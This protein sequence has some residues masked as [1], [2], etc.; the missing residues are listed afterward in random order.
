MQENEIVNAISRL[1][2]IYVLQIKWIG[3]CKLP[4]WS[5]AGTCG[6]VGAFM[7]FVNRL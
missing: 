4:C 1:K 5:I 2:G 6:H 7:T 3:D